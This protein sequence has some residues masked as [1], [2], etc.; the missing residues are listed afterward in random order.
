M[1]LRQNLLLLTLPLCLLWVVPKASAQSN[2]DARTV[3]SAALEV[4]QDLGGT[5]VND[6]AEA[7]QQVYDD[8]FGTEASESPNVE[9][10]VGVYGMPD[11]SMTRELLQ[12]SIQAEVA[13]EDLSSNPAVIAAIGGESV[14]QAVLEQTIDAPLSPEAQEQL[15]AERQEHLDYLWTSLESALTTTDSTYSLA[16]QAFGFDTVSP[17]ESLEGLAESARGRT[18]TQDVLKDMAAALPVL[19]QQAQV[20]TQILQL[21]TNQ[22]HLLNEGQFYTTATLFKTQT[23][24]EQMA[25]EA[26]FDRAIQ[27]N[28]LLSNERA[29]TYERLLPHVEMRADAVG[30]VELSANIGFARREAEDE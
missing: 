1:T 3:L 16:E 24:L 13:A 10:A 27:G 5:V 23:N 9:A 17:V 20:E 22:L 28:L 29:N 6:V 19:G 21:M 25:L 8:F 15:A 26:R 30:L 2:D 4:I 18:A 14:L 11:V 7:S 12:T